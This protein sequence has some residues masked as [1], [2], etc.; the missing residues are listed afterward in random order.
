S[1]G[2]HH[3][4]GPTSGIPGCEYL[5]EVVRRRRTVERRGPAPETLVERR[6]VDR[7]RIERVECCVP[8]S[9]GRAVAVPDLGERVPAIGRF[10]QA[11]RVWTGREP[12]RL[13][14]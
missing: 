3:T 12:L 6:R 8:H 11:D 1:R 5:V 4:V 9:K 2:Q 14:R 13:T 7:L 10:L